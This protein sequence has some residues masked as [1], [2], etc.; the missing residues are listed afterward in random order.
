MQ[1]TEFKKKKE[2]E[3]LTETSSLSSINTTVGTQK[4]CFQGCFHSCTTQASYTEA[5]R[6]KGANYQHH[7]ASTYVDLCL[8]LCAN[9]KQPLQMTV[10]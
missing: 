5:V 10:I 7:T 9:G 6:C 1:I 4:K 2:K 8:C 3:T